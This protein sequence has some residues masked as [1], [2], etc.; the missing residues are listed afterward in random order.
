[1]S[2]QT[3][4]TYAAIAQFLSA[5]MSPEVRQ[6]LAQKRGIAPETVIISAKDVQDLEIEALRDLRRP[7][8]SK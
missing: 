6:D 3:V 5:A 1:M 4:Q 8:R 7:K 2:G